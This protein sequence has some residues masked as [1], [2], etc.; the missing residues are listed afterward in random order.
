MWCFIDEQE[1]IQT[2]MSRDNVCHI[3]IYNRYYRRIQR[4]KQQVEPY[5]FVAAAAL[6]VISDTCSVLM[7]MGVSGDKFL[8][9]SDFSRPELHANKNKIPESDYR[10]QD[11]GAYMISMVQK[12]TYCA[13]GNHSIVAQVKNHH[14][15]GA[16]YFYLKTYFKIVPEHHHQIYE[17]KNK[18]DEIFQDSPGLV[19]MISRCPL[20]LIYPN[21]MN[22]LVNMDCMNDAILHGTKMI[23]NINIGDERLQQS[24]IAT[25]LEECS[26]QLHAK[27]EAFIV[28]LDNNDTEY[29]IQ[30]KLSSPNDNEKLFIPNMKFWETFTKEN[31][32]R[33]IPSLQNKNELTT[34]AA[35]NYRVM[36]LLLFQDEH[37]FPDLRCFFITYLIA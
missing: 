26:T 14:E 4:N 28:K 16:I 19:Y 3:V 18:F 24:G 32:L 9:K 27:D 13:N 7:Y 30:E 37:R 36:A 8:P 33:I 1:Y 12:M 29:L 20:Y 15:K 21:F 2:A 10:N 11:F 5:Y 31:S 25:A 34:N 6:F 17:A 35:V 22:N 23:L